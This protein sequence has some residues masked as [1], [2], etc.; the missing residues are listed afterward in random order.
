MTAFELCPLA[1]AFQ[2]FQA[3]LAQHLEQGEMRRLG[4]GVDLPHDAPVQER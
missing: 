1:A 3:E 2:L 4:I